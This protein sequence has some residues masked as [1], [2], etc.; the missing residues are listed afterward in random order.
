MGL[1]MYA[2][3]AARAKQRDEFYESGELRASCL[4]F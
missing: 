4:I 3:V 1:D 2:Y